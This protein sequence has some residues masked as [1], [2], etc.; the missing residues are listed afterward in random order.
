VNRRIA[1]PLAAVAVVTL[2]GGAV[3]ALAGAGS[4][5]GTESTTAAHTT[6][7]VQRLDLVQHETVAGTLAYDDSHA[8]YA[9]RSGTVTALRRPGAV[10]ERGEALYWVDAEPV[11]LFYGSVPMWRRLDASSSDG[12]DVRQLE[13]NLVALGYDPYASIEVDEDWDW[14]TTAAVKRRQEDLGRTE[15]GAVEL[16][17]IVFLPGSRR[18]G[19]QR[20]T[21]GAPVQPGGEV[22]DTS[23]TSQVVTVALDADKRSLVKTGD[24]VTAELPD[25]ST[26]QGTIADVSKVAE[27]EQDPQSGEEGGPTIEVLIE[28]ARGSKTGYFDEA[29]VD[30]ELVKETAKNVLSVPVHALLAL[31]EGGY[32]VEVVGANGVTR[33]VAVE[34]GMFADGLVEITGKEIAEGAKVVVPA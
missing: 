4:A 30:V 18:I 22:M 32:A 25:G 1:I 9:Q 29:P 15:T 5:S 21:V 11:A 19:E 16:G 12:A 28:L 23:S 13:Q 31:A 3:W 26:V 14:A 20:T 2:A 33:L 34:P 6:A 7:T 10:V 27:S 24:K 8:L 17:E